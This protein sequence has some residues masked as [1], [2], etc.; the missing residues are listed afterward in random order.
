MING[1]IIKDISDKIHFSFGESD[2]TPPVHPI[3]IIIAI[4]FIL[5]LMVILL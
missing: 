1:R 2:P 4:I 3:I 5:Y